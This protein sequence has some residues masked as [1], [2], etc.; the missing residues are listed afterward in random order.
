M[1]IISLNCWGGKKFEDL[2]AFVRREAAATD[3][4]CFQ[5]MVA[6]G[7]KEVTSH[8]LRGNLFEEVSAVLPEHYG[9]FYPAPVSKV[10]HEFLPVGTNLGLATFVSKQ[11]VVRQ[12]GSHLYDGDP[13]GEERLGVSTGI[14][15][16]V[17]IDA[18]K[19][20]LVVNLHGL[21]LED[22]SDDPAKGDTLERLEQSR[23][24]VEFFKDKRGVLVGDFNLR[25]ATE[26]IAMISKAM[27]N[28]IAEYGI[29]NTRNREYAEME[30]WKDYIADYAFTSPGITV[31]DF[32][33]LPDVVSD[34]AP[35]MVEFE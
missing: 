3:I 11:Y 14:A 17:E 32:K 2:M 13:F 25:P 12:S 6:G 35:L 1:R 21:F 22:R 29:T 26:S 27:R 10:W 4:F 8:K 33:V 15:Q 31:Q 18:P 34:H 24:L 9:Y 30:K 5:E 28:L 16:Q 19:Q 23:R 20:F 7:L